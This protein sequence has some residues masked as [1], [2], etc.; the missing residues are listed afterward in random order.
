MRDL[1]RWSPRDSAL[2]RDLHGDD[3]VAWDIQTELLATVVDLLAF[4]NWQ[5]GGG[6]GRRPRPVPRPHKRATIGTPIGL[7]ELDARLGWK[8]PRKG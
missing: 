3:I 5:R 1:L 2:A 8:S 6:K 4:A 7:D